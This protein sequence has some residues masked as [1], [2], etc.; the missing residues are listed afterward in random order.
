[1]FYFRHNREVSFDNFSKLSLNQFHWIHLESRPNHED[2]KLMLKHVLK[3]NKDTHHKI[4]T[5]VEVEKPKHD[6]GH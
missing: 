5:S 6:T 3:H 2:Q 4:I 1:M